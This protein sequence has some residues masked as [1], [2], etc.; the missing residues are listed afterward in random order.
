MIIRNYA[1]GLRF[2]WITADNRRQ[3]TVQSTAHLNEL[4]TLFSL[5]T[6]NKADNQIILIGGRNPKIPGSPKYLTIY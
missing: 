3:T 1:S 2:V 5:V 4:Q 6:G